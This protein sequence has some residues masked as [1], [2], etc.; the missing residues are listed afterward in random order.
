VAVAALAVLGFTFVQARRAGARRARASADYQRLVG[1]LG[2][3]ATAAPYWD[4][5]SYDPRLDP[6]CGCALWPV[7]G[8]YLYSPEHLTTVFDPPQLLWPLVRPGATAGVPL[9]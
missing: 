3:G 9:R 6:D 7:P 8:G 2:M 1:G 5:S 4:F